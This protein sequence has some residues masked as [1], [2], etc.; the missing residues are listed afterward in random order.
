MEYTELASQP[1]LL[2]WAI[3][4][5]GQLVTSLKFEL[6]TSHIKMQSNTNTR[7]NGNLPYAWL[8]AWPSVIPKKNNCI[9]MHHL[10]NIYY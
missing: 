1:P 8:N 10:Q 2:F 5:I 6:G 4:K 7:L 9:I 3:F